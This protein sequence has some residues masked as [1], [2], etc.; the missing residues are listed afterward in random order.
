[1]CRNIDSDDDAKILQEDLRKLFQWSVD[2]QMLFNI[3]K[4]SVMH[5]GKFNN[6]NE[7][8]L[9][10]KI[11]ATTEEERDMG[12]I[13]NSSMNPSRQCMEAAKKGN[14]ML[15]MIKRT[16][17]SRDKEIIVKLY[18][19]LVRPHLEYCVQAW[20]P[21]LK[22]D[23]ELLEKVQ[24]RATKMVNGCHNLSYERRLQYC[25]L[26]TLERRRERGDLIETYKIM[27]GKVD[28]PYDRY[29]TLAHY[30]STR[31]HKCKLFKQRVGPR[32]KNVFSARVVDKWNSLDEAGVTVETINGFKG[33]LGKQGY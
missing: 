10:G 22:K 24:R 32:K 20:N 17:V 12:V 14:R 18:K 5:V 6:G 9:G 31:G 3:D 16:I 28:V 7:Y 21:F 25:G 23:I 30:S 26:T 19:S 33:Y 15:G 29:F 11:L 2:W 27:T 4:C 1:M 8:A 13:I